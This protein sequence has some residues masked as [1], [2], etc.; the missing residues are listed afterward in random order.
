MILVDTSVWVDFFHD[1]P[2]PQVA[3]LKHCLVEGQDLCI[4][5]LIL[6]EVLQGIR[7][8]ADHAKT[9]SLFDSLLFLPM[10]RRTFLHAAEMYRALRREGTTIRKAVDGLIAAVALEHD[11]PLLHHDRDFLP[12]E[13]AFGL[14]TADNSW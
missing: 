8:D 9:L 7:E 11:V 1:R 2:I 6:T 5:G 13:R 12:Y 4:C 10:T 14:K 3:I